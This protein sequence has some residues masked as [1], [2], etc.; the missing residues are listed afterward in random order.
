MTFTFTWLQ[1]PRYNVAH[2]AKL[3]LQMLEVCGSYPDITTLA[4]QWVLVKI[5]FMLKIKISFIVLVIPF[6][7]F[8]CLNRQPARGVGL[9]QN[10]DVLWPLKVIF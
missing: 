7:P 9:G 3:F 5:N 6:E 1:L 2:L 4:N 8:K 10:F